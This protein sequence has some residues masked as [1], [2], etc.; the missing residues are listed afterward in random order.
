MLKNDADTHI[1]T[2]VCSGI[3]SCEYGINPT[4]IVTTDN[5]L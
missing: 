5:L 4:S 2:S 1:I 3:F